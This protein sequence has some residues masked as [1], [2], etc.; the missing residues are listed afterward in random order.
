VAALAASLA[1]V[2]VRPAAVADA[3]EVVTDRPPPARSTTR[4]LVGAAVASGFLAFGAGALN[5]WLVESGVDAGLSNGTAGLMLSGGAA[6]GIAVR[7]GWG[8][9]LDTLDRL[10]FRIAGL[11][12]FAGA[13][14]MALLAVRV[15]PVHVAATVVAFAGGWIWPVF[16]NFGVVRANAGH[17]AAATGIT[18]T[19]VYAGVL[20]APL[21]TGLLID[22]AGYP[23]MWL[24]VAVAMVVGATVALR[25]AHHF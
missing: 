4:A 24:T 11:M 8:V 7:V 3:D 1:L 17:A 5:A 12:A 23:A 6:L 20:A 10:P 16:T 15:A 21:V 9:R 22:H 19:G 18:Q 2:V 14:G 25:V 13:A